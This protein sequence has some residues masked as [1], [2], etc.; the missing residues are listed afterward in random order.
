MVQ[1]N[2]REID[3]LGMSPEAFVAALQAFSANRVMISTSGIAANYP[4]KLPFHFQNPYAQ[5][6]VLRE[7][8]EACHAA[9]IRVIARMDFS[10][11]RRPIA[12]K[13]PE[14]MFRDANGAHVDYRG[15]VHICFNSEYQQELALQIMEETVTYLHAD[16][17]FLNMAGYT[18]G[19][20]Y[21]G[22]FY[23]NCSCANCRRRYREIIG[24]DMPD[25]VRETD[26]ENYARFQ[27]TTLE[28]YE[29]KVRGFLKKLRPDLLVGIADMY[30]MDEGLYRAEAG[31]HFRDL[32]PSWAY[33]A[34]EAANYSRNAYPGM[35]HSV[36]T[37]DFADMAYRLAGVSPYEHTWRL[38]SVLANGADP[39]YY[40]IGRLDDHEDRSGFSAVQE[41]F[42]FHSEHEDAYVGLRS[43]AKIAVVKPKQAFFFSNPA[44]EEYRGWFS[45]LKQRHFQADLLRA[46]TAG[47]RLSAYEAVILPDCTDLPEAFC[48]ELDRF[49]QNGGRLI[50][51][52]GAGMDAAG[53]MQLS[54][55]GVAGRREIRKD[56]KPAYFQVSGS[57]Y[58]PGLSETEL[59][60]LRG[61]YFDCEYADS[62]ETCMH[63]IPPHPH[64]P[65]EKAYY[66]SV[67]RSPGMAINRWGRGVAVYF[68][69]RIGRQ[70]LLDGQPGPEACMA[71]VLTEICSVQPLKS[72]LPPAVELT[73]QAKPGGGWLLH[74]V[75]GSGHFGNTSAAPIPIRNAR[76]VLAGLQITHAHDLRT[77][78]N[79]RLERSDRETTVFLPEFR[80]FLVLEIQ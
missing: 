24:E 40:V 20:D 48:R 44:V 33:T 63:L 54:C 30:S 69:W 78:Q 73:L 47:A 21:S 66:S 52:A 6:D 38:A 61:D 71:D 77:G 7:T 3:M 70:Y 28:E 22:N 79:C 72:D 41:M 10:K 2:L 58:L 51:V 36:A 57:R 45:L 35:V 76:V 18:G 15:D 62:V 5:G 31:N 12:E 4:T 26:A 68:P 55:T 34:A 37:V 17:V 59:L 46:E 9:G 64:A 27:K 19:F 11:L 16:G 50:V 75:N 53:R 14:W 43:T 80:D 13:H 8:V 67:T 29:R 56:L 39:D 25:D 49:V 42:R 60:Y 65:P 1:T 32:A 74:A 23:G